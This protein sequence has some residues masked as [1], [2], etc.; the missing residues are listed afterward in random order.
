VAIELVH[1]FTF[2]ARL[3]PSVPVGPGPFGTRRIREVLGGEV[4]GARL[5][6]Q[7]GTGGVHRLT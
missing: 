3:A 6:G 4:T 1:E 7:V 2:T 5:R